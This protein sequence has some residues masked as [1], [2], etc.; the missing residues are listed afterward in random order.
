ML[1]RRCC[2]TAKLGKSGKAAF[3]KVFYSD[4]AI[5]ANHGNPDRVYDMPIL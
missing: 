3:A 1:I 2:L 5:I 4:F